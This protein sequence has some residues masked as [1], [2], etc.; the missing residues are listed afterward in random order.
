[1][2]GWG[3]A[4]EPPGRGRSELA[5]ALIGVAASALASGAEGAARSVK[6]KW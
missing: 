1:M 6:S 5:S 2:G 3:A 4:R